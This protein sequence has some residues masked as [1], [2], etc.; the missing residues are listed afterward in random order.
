MRVHRGDMSRVEVDS[1]LDD[2]ASGNAEIMALKVR[3]FCSGLL[4]LRQ[5]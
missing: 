3:A 1:D 5:V 2:L 4:G